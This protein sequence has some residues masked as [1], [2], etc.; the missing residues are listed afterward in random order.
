MSYPPRAKNEKCDEIPAAVKVKLAIA[1]V[2]AAGGLV[3]HYF[4]THPF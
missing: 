3:Y 4:N 1:F 2:I